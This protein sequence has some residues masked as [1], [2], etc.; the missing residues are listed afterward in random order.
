M[1]IIFIAAVSILA[2]EYFFILP[3]D[4]FGKGLL[5]IMKKSIWI[6]TSRR[7]SDHWKEIVLLRYAMEILKTT[8]LLLLILLGLVILVLIS[9]LFFDWLVGQELAGENAL[10]QPGNW[11]FMTLVAFIYLYFRNCYV[12]R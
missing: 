5:I 9:S 6:L 10:S 4:K 1:S 8:I 12:N 2:V 11:V 3:F 7:I